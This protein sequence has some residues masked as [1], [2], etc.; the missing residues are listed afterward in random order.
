M[1][2]DFGDLGV[3]YGGL[4]PAERLHCLIDVAFNL[5]IEFRGLQNLS[6]YE[7]RKNGFAIN[8]VQNKLL[9]QA[10]AELSGSGKYPDEVLISIIRDIASS[11]GVENIILAAFYAGLKQVAYRRKLAI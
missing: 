4:Q 8:E 9:S 10:V 5:T 11:E 7:L 1:T 3:V 2:D 6:D